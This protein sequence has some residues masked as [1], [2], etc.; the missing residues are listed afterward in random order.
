MKKGDKFVLGMVIFI[1][2]LCILS[3]GYYFIG[4][5][6][7]NGLVAEVYRDGELLRSIDLEKVEK[8]D[9][10]K[11]EDSDGDFNIIEFENGKIRFKES[12]CKDD[13]CVKT[14]WLSRK[15][16]MAVCIPHKTYIKIVGESKELDGV[17]F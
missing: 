16:E 3:I 9:E 7:S 17:S 2:F 14:G 13:V 15:G 4:G 8:P 12:N 10:F 1:F 11:V 6:N 5:S